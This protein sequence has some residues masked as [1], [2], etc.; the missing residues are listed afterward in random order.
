L[1]LTHGNSMKSESLP[2]S[3][4]LPVEIKDVVSE[5]TPLTEHKNSEGLKAPTKSPLPQF[6]MTVSGATAT[7]M[8][9][10]LKAELA[11]YNIRKLG[12][13]RH[14]VKF[15]HQRCFDTNNLP[16]DMLR[17]FKV[18][19]ERHG[20]K[21]A[22]TIVFTIRT[23][24]EL[25]RA[26]HMTL[27]TSKVLQ[28]LKDTFDLRM[29]WEL[30]VL[31][32]KFRIEDGDYELHRKVPYDY[33]SEFQDLYMKIAVALMEGHIDVNAALLYQTETKQ[34]KHTA[35]GGLFL[36]DFP[37]R[38]ILYPLEAFTCAIVFFGG[39]WMDGG[40]AALTGFA[41]GLIEYWL[42][43]VGDVG[44]II[45]D[46]AVGMS[47][48]V[49][50]GLFYRYMGGEH[51]LSAIALG[52]LYWFFYGTA[53]VIGLLEIVAGEL[54]TGVTRFIAVSVK[55][56]VLCLGASFGLQWV[57]L[58]VNQV[59]R[60][61]ANN[62]NKTFNIADQWFRLPMYVLC[63]ASCLGQ[64][65]FP[66]VDYWRGLVVQVV[67]YEVQF[68]LQQYWEDSHSESQSNIDSAA[69]NLVGAAA[70]VVAAV[71]L[72][73]FINLLRRPYYARLLQRGKR[74]KFDNC[75]YC[76]TRACVKAG[77][78][79]HLLR[80]S[81][82]VKVRME[83]EL[84]QRR[85][86]TEEE[87]VLEENEES[88]L[89][90]TFVD[91]QS[92]NIWAILMPA[93]YM[94]VPGSMIAKLWFNSIFPP[95]LQR[96]QVNGTTLYFS[97]AV[98]DNVFANLMVISTSLALGLICGFVIV[99][100]GTQLRDAVAAFCVR[101]FNCCRN[102][103]CCCCRCCR[104]GAE[105]KDALQQST[106]SKLDIEVEKCHEQEAVDMQKSRFDGMFTVPD[107]DPSDGESDVEEG[108]KK[109][110]PKKRGS[111]QAPRKSV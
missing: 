24:V 108:H 35:P 11:R 74:N 96:S 54:L 80:Q 7:S 20:Q 100:L 63:S 47:T 59:W 79:F 17:V 36:R 43:T 28:Q 94:L 65:R 76:I 82:A 101:C 48:G 97:D 49:I 45:L 52:T 3:K 18:L 104:R 68:R 69:S 16:R 8:V 22:L 103:C 50:S 106:Q 12:S 77:Y 83:R 42:S 32:L 9:S 95:P 72:Y 99:K 64:Y 107:E 84:M 91:A 66:I 73:G 39:D 105:E 6:G 55:T 71:L 38:L 31:R 78:V 85:E 30:G 87:I 86:Q 23:A 13:L 14:I 81:E 15:Q 110:V 70:A 57:S 1:V 75:C 53:F 58:D 98:Q 56:F 41:A 93:V 21:Y 4:D 5:L 111:K 46:L 26:W 61:Q 62:C 102:R 37:G 33:D 10:T 44:K 51:C 109:P 27:L 88:A 67:A 25:H 40:V 34:G 90:E 92:P 2:L 60:D 19:E 89:I 29:S